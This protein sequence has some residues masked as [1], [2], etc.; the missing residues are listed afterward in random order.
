MCAELLSVVQAHL[1]GG[2]QL[3]GLH[4]RLLDLHRRVSGPLQLQAASS[5][6]VLQHPWRKLHI[7]LRRLKQ[8]LAR[9]PPHSSR[10]SRSRGSSSSCQ[11]QV[12]LALSKAQL[13]QRTAALTQGS[14]HSSQHPS[15]RAAS[16]ILQQR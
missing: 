16:C 5:S 7:S 13:L 14:S 1:L 2:L 15:I 6:S 12:V 9:C 10:G 3:W 8:G 11:Q 4:L